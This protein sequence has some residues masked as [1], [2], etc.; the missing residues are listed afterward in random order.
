MHK[1]GTYA[2][3]FWEQVVNGP[4]T[5]NLK[6][7]VG[8]ATAFNSNVSNTSYIQQTA[9]VVL[10]AGTNNVLFSGAYVSGFTIGGLVLDDVSL[11][12]LSAS[13][14]SLP[15]GLPTNQTNAGNAINN[16]FINIGGTLPTNLNLFNLSSS[17]LVTALTQLDGETSTD[18]EKGAFALMN[19]FLGLMLD[20]FVDGR[21]GGNGQPLG[22]APDRQ[23]D[24]PPDIA[25]AYASVLKAPRSAQ[26]AQTFNQRWTAWGSGFGGTSTTN[27]NGSTNVTA[28]DYGFAGGMV[29]HATPETAYG[30]AFAGGGTNWGLAQ[31][32]GTGRSDAFRGWCLRDDTFWPDLPRRRARLHQQLVHD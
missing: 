22:F 27:G 18:A 17:Q 24:F 30:F 6:A 2:F 9:T 12:L 13:T 11:M 31:G 3:S 8:T 26:A 21:F 7:T 4:A 19:Q 14:L 23:A 16:N 29:Y 1:N 28:R 25:L 32:L 5:F 10:T 15:Q 20:P